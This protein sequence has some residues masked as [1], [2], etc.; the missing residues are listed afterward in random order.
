MPISGRE[1]YGGSSLLNV[2]W[3]KGIEEV[4]RRHESAPDA[5]HLPHELEATPLIERVNTV[6]E[7]VAAAAGLESVR[8]KIRY[9]G[10]SGL[11]HRKGREVR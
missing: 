7:N 10:G 3:E 11:L 6:L 5:T 4:Q 8:F 9:D 1:R 2:L